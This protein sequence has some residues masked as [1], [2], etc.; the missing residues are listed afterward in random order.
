MNSQLT[1]EVISIINT[2]YLLHCCKHKSHAHFSEITVVI[3]HSSSMWLTDRMHVHVIFCDY[4]VFYE[5]GGTHTLLLLS[6]LNKKVSQIYFLQVLYT[7]SF[8]VKY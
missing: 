8:Q 1:I 2:K 4:L 3:G 7:Q 5:L 6:T